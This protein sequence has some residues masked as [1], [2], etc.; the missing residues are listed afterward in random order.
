MSA[1]NAVRYGANIALGRSPFII[2]CTQTSFYFSFRSFRIHQREQERGEHVS[3][4]ER[5]ARE[6]KI[7]VYHARSKDFE[8]K[9]EGL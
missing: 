5:G 1:R 7:I 6:R 9:V 3:E 8:D 4:S 2:A